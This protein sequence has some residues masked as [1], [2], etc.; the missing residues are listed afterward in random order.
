MLSDAQVIA[1]AEAIEAARHAARQLSA[2]P[3]ELTPGT[4]AE[5]YRIQAARTR[6]AGPVVG[7][8]VGAI[9][10]E[11]RAKLGTDRPIGAPMLGPYV[12]TSPARFSARSFN[13]LFLECEFAFRLGRDLPARKAA[14]QRH[15]VEAAVDALVPLVELVDF[16]IPPPTTLPLMLADA[17]ANGG[18][19]NGQPIRDWRGRNL[20]TA[21]IVLT[22]DGKSA[23]EG[24]GAAIL[25]DPFAAVV[26]L[27]NTQPPIGEGLRAGQVI[28]TGS[29]TGL[30]PIDAGAHAIADYGALGRIEIAVDG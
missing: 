19:V 2:L 14:Y 3:P 26:M 21:A 30:T 1:A 28:T 6:R 12:F 24:T 25:G 5:G 13:G 9:N 29:C 18:F 20:A 22:I 17:M 15:E 10:V 7:W 16:R 11:Q 4:A 8:K 27:A 23:A